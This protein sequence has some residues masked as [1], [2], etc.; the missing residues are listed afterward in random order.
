MGVLERDGELYTGMVAGIDCM[1][2]ASGT[3]VVIETLVKLNGNPS[4]SEIT[5]AQG[6]AKVMVEQAAR[7]TLAQMCAT[8]IYNSQK[9]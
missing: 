9:E 7:S 1:A 3:P 8:C 6:Q 2:T 5:K 4:D